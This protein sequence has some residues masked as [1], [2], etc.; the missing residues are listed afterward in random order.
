MR[1]PT[2]VRSDAD[3]PDGWHL[4]DPAQGGRRWAV[5][6]RVWLRSSSLV[7][8]RACSRRVTPSGRSRSLAGQLRKTFVLIGGHAVGSASGALVLLLDAVGRL[9]R[10]LRARP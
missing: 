3:L 1:R 9:G 8:P 4:G 6:D 5:N 10:R 2:A 7:T